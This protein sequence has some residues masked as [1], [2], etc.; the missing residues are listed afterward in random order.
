MVDPLTIGVIVVG[1][2]TAAS[3]YQ[4]RKMQREAEKQA[5]EMASHQISGHDS[6]RALYTVYGR[7]LV[8]TTTL[9]KRVSRKQV[10]MAN[11][12]FTNYRG[13]GGSPDTS[14]KRWGLN[15]FL[16]RIS[17]LSNGPIDGIEKV[18]I[19]GESHLASRFTAGH[20]R[21]FEAAV[22][23]G[24]TAGNYFSNLKTTYSTD[25]SQWDSSKKGQGVAYVVERF[26]FD[27][28][29]PAYQGEPQ[30]QYLVRG[31]KLYDPR[32]DSTVAGGSGSHRSATPSTWAFSDNPALALLDMLTNTEYGR[33][34]DYSEC[35]LPSFITAANKCDT[36]V[37][38]PAR[39]TNQTGSQLVVYDPHLGVTYEI[40]DNGIIP[41]YRM[42][43]ITTG[44]FANKQKRFRLNM[45]VDNSKEV[46]DNIQQILQSFRANLHHINGEYAVHMDDVASPVI[47]LNDDDIIGGLKISQG[48]RKQRINRMTAK[49]LNANKHYKTDQV[50]WPPL[51]E[52]SGSQYQTYLTADSGEKLHKTVTLTGCTD[53][54]QA[55]DI[56]EYL[57]RES[58]VTLTATGTFGSRCFNL[59]PGDVVALDYD[60]AGYSGKYFIVDQVGVDISSMNVK[61]SLREYDSSIYTWNANRGNEPIGLFFDEEQQYNVTPTSPTIGTVSADSIALSDGTAALRLNIPFS[62]IP[63]EALSVEI[64]WSVQNAD[65]YT[66]QVILDETATKA[67]FLIGIDDQ[68][69]DLRIRYFVANADGIQLPSGYSTTTFTLPAVSGTKLDNIEDNATRNQVFQQDAQPSGGAY[70]T[71]DIWID[72]NDN[73]K[74][75]MYDSGAWVLRADSRIATALQDAAG[76]QSTADGK[77]DTFYQDNAPTSASEG[78]LWIDTND[79]NKLYRYDGTNWQAARDSGIAEAIADAE[80]AQSTADGKITTFFAASTATPTAEGVG[81]MWYQTDNA[82]MQRWNGSTWNDVASYNTGD[83]ADLDTVGNSQIDNDSINIDKLDDLQSTNY[84]QGVSGWKLTKDGTFETG[85]GTFRGEVTATSGTIGGFSIGSTALTAGSGSSAVGIHTVKGIYLGATS[86][87]S[88]PFRVNTAGQLTATNASITG[89]VTA[90][91]GAIAGINIDATKLY[92]GTGDWANSNTGFYLDNAGKFSLKD[93]LFFDPSNNTLT[94]DGNITADVITAKQNL[95]VLGDLQA[96]SVAA[97]SITRAMLSQ[98]ALDEIFGSL[99]SSV[100]GSNGDFKDGTGTFTTSGGSVTLGTSSDKFNHGSSDVEVEFNINTFFYSTT[101]Y[102]QAQAQATLTF[103]ATADGTFNDLN[104]ADKTHTLQFLEYDLSSY[105]GYT[106]LV[107][108]INTAITKTFTSG[109]GSDLADNT[110]VQFKVAVSSVGSAFTNQTLPFSVAANEGVTGVTSTGGN[111]DTLDN[112]DSTAFLRSNVDDTFDADLTI[113]GDLSLQ[114]ALN[115][116]GDINSYNVTDLDVTDKT[117]TVNSGNAQELSDGSGLIV[118][119]GTADSASITWSETN[120]RFVIT[121]G[122]SLENGKNLRIANAGSSNG[123]LDLANTTSTYDWLLYH[124]DNGSVILTISGTG[125][126][127]FIFDADAS[128][129]TSATLTVGGSQI[130]ATKISQWNT[131]YGWGNH[132]TQNYAVTTGDT[133]TGN[134]TLGTGTDSTALVFPDKNVD[135]DP[136]AASDKRQLIKMGNGG[137]GGMYQTTGRGGLMI[138]SADDSVIIAS[139]DIG[140]NFDPN[141]GGQNPNPDSEELYLV[142]DGGIRFTTGLQGGF[143]GSADY[144][145]R[146][147]IL[148]QHGQLQ[149][150]TSGT[151][152][153]PTYS[154][155][156]DVNTGMY[157]PSNDVLGFSAGGHQRMRVT[158]SAVQNYVKLHTQTYTASSTLDFTNVFRV[159]GLDVASHTYSGQQQIRF[160]HGSW[161]G[162]YYLNS[163]SP[164]GEKENIRFTSHGQTQTNNKIEINDGTAWRKVL[165]ETS[166]ITV[167]KVT[168]SGSN[169]VYAG[170]F[171]GETAPNTTSLGVKIVTTNGANDVALLVEQ[172][173]GTDLFKITGQGV[174]SFSQRISVQNQDITGT[175]IENWQDAYSWGDHADA[176]YLLSETSHTDVVVDG[177]FNST[178]LMKRGSSAG[179]YSVIADNSSN[180]NTAYGDKINS[181]N[182][183]TST[184]I[185]TLTRQDAGTVTVDLDGR[186][187][188]IDSAHSRF[189]PP[190]QGNL[191]TYPVY[192]K[193]AEVNTGNGGLHLKGQLNNH[194]E[195]F[196]TQDFDITIYGREQNSGQNVEIAGSFNVGKSGVG[197]RVVQATNTG[198]YYRYD[199]Y[200][201]LTRYSLVRVDLYKFG[202][203]SLVSSPTSTTTQ[204]TGFAVELDTTSKIEGSYV[205]QNSLIYNNLHSGS[206]LTTAGAITAG[207]SSSSLGY[208]VGS[209][210]V[211]NGNRDLVNIGTIGSG[212]IT[213]S[214]TITATTTLSAQ[215]GLFSGYVDANG[216]VNA[217]MFRV[218]DTTVIDSN[219]NILNINSIRLDSTADVTLSSTGHA[220]QTGSAN[221]VNLAIDNNE[222][223]ARNNGSSSS[224][225]L[226]GDGGAVYVNANLSAKVF[227]QGGATTAS[228]TIEGA[229]NQDAVLKL[230]ETGTGDV[231]AHLYYDGGDNKLHIKTGN[232]TPATRMTFLRD[233]TAVGIGNVNPSKTLDVAGE[234]RSTAKITVDQGSYDPVQ[235]AAMSYSG[236]VIQ[237]NDGNM[238]LLSYDDNSSVANNIGFGRFSSTDGSLIHKFGIT[239]WANTGSQGSNTGNKLSFNYGTNTN[240]WSNAEKF[241]ITS[242]GD[243]TASNNITAQGSFITATASSAQGIYAGSTQVF[244][245]STRNLK[246]IGTISAGSTTVNGQLTFTSNLNLGSGLTRLVWG[247]GASSGSSLRNYLAPRNDADDAWN[248]S[249]EFGYDHNA[250]AWY[251]DDQ[252]HLG[253]RLTH[254]DDTD[255]YLQFDANRIRLIANGTTK[256]D[257]NNTYVTTGDIADFIE[258]EADTL[259]SV[260]GRGATT[261]NDV[262]VGHLGVDGASSSSYPLYVHG[263]IA[264]SSGS[265]YSFGDFIMGNG[266]LKKGSTT[267]IDSSRNILNVGTITSSGKLEVNQA[268]NGTSN[269]PSS[270][271]ELSGQESTGVLKA[272]SLVNSVNATFGNGT[273]LAFHNA[274]MYSP[275]GAVRVIQAGDVVT[276]S[277]MVLQIYRGG[278]KDAVVIDHDENMTVGNNITADGSFITA[279]SSSAQGIYAGSTQVFEG[280]TRNLKNIGTISSGALTSTSAVS[281]LA[282]RISGTDVITSNRVVKPTQYQGQDFV[283][284][285]TTTASIHKMYGVVLGHQPEDGHVTSPFFHN[286]LGNF[287]ARGGTVTVGGLSYTPAMTNAFKAHGNSASWG[288]ANYSGSTMT[289]TLTT[290]P[291]NLNYGGYIGISFGNSSWAPASL[292]IE[293]S[294]DGGS[295]WTTRLNDS[296]TKTIYFTTTGTGGTPLNAI[297]FTIGQAVNT[298][299]IRVTNIWAYNYNSNGM[300]NYFIDKAGDTLYGELSFNDANTKLLEGGGNRIRVQTDSGYVEVGAGNTG[301]AHF[302]TDRPEYYFDKQIKVDT[303]IIGSYNEDLVLRRAGNSGDQITLTTTGVTFASGYNLSMSG[304]I[305]SG[306]ITAT[307]Q[308]YTTRADRAF[309]AS[310]SST[311]VQVGPNNQGAAGT[312][313]AHRLTTN[314]GLDYTTYV[315][316]DC[317]YDDSDEKWHALRTNL[318]RKWKTNFGGYHQNRFTISTYDGGGTSGS[319]ISAGWLEADWEE[320][321]GVDAA[322]VV[323]IGDSLRIGSTTVITSSRNLVNI[324][325]IS[326]AAITSSGNMSLTGELDITKSGSPHSLI[327]GNR[328]NFADSSDDALIWITSG[329]SGGFKSGAGA[330][331]VFEGRKANRN[332]YF[333]VGNVTAPQHIMSSNGYVGFGIGDATPTD[334]VQVSGT[335]R[336]DSYKVGTNTVIDSSR[337]ITAGTISSGAITSTG[338]IT[339]SGSIGNTSHT[340]DTINGTF[341]IFESGGTFLSGNFS[342]GLTTSLYRVSGTTVISSGRELQNIVKLKTNDGTATAPS[343]TFTNDT[344]SGM[345]SGGADV[346][347][348]TSGGVTGITLNSDTVALIRDN[349]NVKDYLRHYGDSDTYFRFTT[350]R[351]R[352][353]AGNVTFMDANEGTTDYLRFPTR[354]VTIGDNTAPNG[355]LTIEHDSTETPAAGGGS[356]TFLR[357]DNSNTTASA[358]TVIAFNANDAGGNTRHGAGIQFKKSSLWAGNGSYPGELLFWTRPSSGDQAA[359][360]KLD[361]DG[362]AIFKGN[363]TAYGSLSDRRLKKNIENITDAVGK[364]QE[365]N[366]VTFDYKKDGKRAT[367]LIAQDLEKVL[368]EAVYTSSDIETSEEHLAIH[369]GNVVGLLVEAIKE[370]KQEIEDLK[371]GDNE[372]N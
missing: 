269:V 99:A 113:T 187:Q 36:Y 207:G 15:R 278:L 105:Y 241:S 206:V 141:A 200:I 86:F 332:F 246:N 223:Q 155:N 341:R 248:Y 324:G 9:Y 275:T 69:I 72:T 148:S 43:Q 42:D 135:D 129:Y 320:K 371:N 92:A 82:I 112:L 212:A 247:W 195:S 22:S 323:D 258:S 134:L 362:N 222:I 70:Q 7:A 285:G 337:N 24:P 75:Y 74:M 209:T 235:S 149:M 327:L 250:N 62:D 335:L 142:T 34:V 259:D 78:D 205:I 257:T 54:Y 139:G 203:S 151:A 87:S 276:D 41:N 60:S 348:F 347:K 230:L 58:R 47:T 339:T 12:S 217:Y 166:N 273:E 48:D 180:W 100:G 6:N 65:V 161:A 124:Q 94:V 314:T 136:D 154:F 302:V 133:F 210:Q 233:T 296:S 35:D 184:G 158:T 85:D 272:L 245:G 3:Y 52:T 116:T 50:S 25:F 282:I 346:V 73:F 172:T 221:G 227:F 145:P 153:R 95:V 336:A 55:E 295:T 4:Q 56:A 104:S 131:A 369:Y 28:S 357:F 283:R 37:D 40:A 190:D 126:G 202:S 312:F 106:Y 304:S 115:I 279:T 17:S 306:A 234:I 243:V 31:R 170:V 118:D 182:F 111:A 137:N 313:G 254:K 294:T 163:G 128:D 204:P 109:S 281:G 264:Q 260:T 89:A 220:F 352:M 194:V 261:T 290:L 168:A 68:V 103:E 5:N 23:L 19:D 225:Y 196:G 345:F 90:T 186:F 143:S 188:G 11:A 171:T 91:D 120:D 177:D 197:V 160:Y 173:D 107:Y 189:T 44:S 240:P 191:S 102:T 219:R 231:G 253:H 167:G 71:G 156:G 271:A 121:D 198:T 229:P 18:L 292:K 311:Y 370:L 236:L 29:N 351:I 363:V 39:A 297:R 307:G 83:L 175:R 67:E 181:A 366:G 342:Y 45:A 309:Y 81:D 165:T 138:A 266:G 176:N 237:S 353:V 277:K 216:L 199:V 249:H 308:I 96:S 356:T 150:G 157:K 239:H 301:H 284:T 298:T 316:Y 286:D 321:F 147:A 265:I 79:D 21:H 20:S 226:Q 66:S 315:G 64:G 372:D 232:S 354:A 8:G 193:V 238:D 358:S 13:G 174:G 30:T 270:V 98:D 355:C 322:G 88:S 300:H 53:Y 122:L 328:D 256:I 152:D 26:W 340:L 27:K 343:H 114:G 360:Q 350:D 329:N 49:F 110:D 57:V 10:P 214:S 305:S 289:V 63:E 169:N 365:L 251:I 319:S 164:N 367:G 310:N 361:K 32:L 359:A 262:Q 38:I 144:T 228:A 368:P 267:V 291:K 123:R 1:A 16:Y 344:N 162:Y 97:G 215:D 185:L 125:G 132:S 84:S 255:T 159:N 326:S 364:V 218:D 338:N 59:V 318:G 101:N 117:I 263:S 303:G 146:T 299:S 119:R 179:S 252:L 333:K 280:S 293:I 349:V 127:E 2:L 183:N 287:E 330:H 325:T 288:N 108:H 211:I 14:D 51:D 178:G 244:E 61:L 268:G 208:Y 33:G 334:R 77:I 274:S 331:L 130:S 213:S 201:V 93:K 140:R 242:G 80:T 224:L 46:L 317:Y 192:Y 76:A